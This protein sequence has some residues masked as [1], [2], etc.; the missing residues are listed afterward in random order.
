MEVE[1]LSGTFVILSGTILVMLKEMGRSAQRYTVAI[2]KI[3][4]KF[5]QNGKNLGSASPSNFGY[6][7]PTAGTTAV[8]C[9]LQSLF[10]SEEVNSFMM[11]LI[12]FGFGG[13]LWSKLLSK[14]LDTS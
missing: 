5:V 1:V 10:L 3:G 9:R 4:E 7:P 14:I 6:S 8:Y 13:A 2:E 12:K 11:T